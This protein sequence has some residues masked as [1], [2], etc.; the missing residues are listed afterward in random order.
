MSDLLE[1]LVAERAKHEARQSEH[2]TPNRVWC[3]ECGRW[4]VGTLC[5][6]SRALDGMIV[7][8]KLCIGC[9]DLD[10]LDAIQAAYRGNE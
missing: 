8:V 6:L 4:F 3:D 5:P 1:E 7:S 10:G 2:E 9:D